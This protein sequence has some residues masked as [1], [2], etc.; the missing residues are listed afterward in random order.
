MQREELKINC[1]TFRKQESLIKD[2]T[3]KINRGQGVQE[4]SKWACE[5]QKEAGVLLSCADFDD[6]S[7]DCKNCRFVAN[8]RKK[9]ADLI[10][11]AKKLA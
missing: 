4:K 9:T 1:Q 11:K 10:V 5:L 8:L 3:G 6:K 7:L 2:I